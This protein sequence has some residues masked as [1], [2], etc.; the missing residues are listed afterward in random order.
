MAAISA[1]WNSTAPGIPWRK[2]IMAALALLLATVYGA[3]AICKHLDHAY[4]V[5]QCIERNGPLQTWVNPETGRQALVCQFD[6]G[7]FGIMIRE[8]I[9][10]AQ[11]LWR[12]ITSF[13]KERMSTI[14]QVMQYLRNT[15]YV[16][17]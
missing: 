9:D 12:E 2:L 10:E 1:N 3:H 17:K 15:G 14:D 11:D 5:R 7:K 8:A 13:T 16:P 6:T 4:A